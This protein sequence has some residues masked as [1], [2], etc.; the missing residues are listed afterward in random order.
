MTQARQPPAHA[1][2]RQRPT[3]PDS[4]SPAI[5]H[6]KVNCTTRLHPLNPHAKPTETT[7]Q[8]I[9]AGPIH[10]VRNPSRFSPQIARGWSKNLRGGG[11][12][13]CPPS[14]RKLALKPRKPRKPALE[15][16]GGER[17]GVPML[18]VI[19]RRVLQHERASLTWDSV[20]TAETVPPP[21]CGARDPDRR[22]CPRRPPLLRCAARS[23]SRWPLPTLVEIHPIPQTPQKRRRLPPQTRF[24]QP[25]SLSFP[26][27]PVSQLLETSRRGRE[28]PSGEGPCPTKRGDR[29][30]GG[31]GHGHGQLAGRSFT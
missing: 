28:G 19:E 15:P 27:E 29:C 18:K 23:V 5:V 8:P 3:A 20:E 16:A 17:R 7:N 14:W 31:S 22:V 26:R 13:G 1:S 10:R 12:P 9:N 24:P 2:A 25:N 21:A 4:A 30:G 11:G 6:A